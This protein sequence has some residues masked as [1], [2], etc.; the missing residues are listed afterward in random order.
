MN[1]SMKPL[2]IF[3]HGKVSGPKGN[4]IQAL[5]RVCLEQGFDVESLD[6]RRLHTNERVTKLNN[7]LMNLSRPYILVGTSMGGYVSAVAG[8]SNDPMGIFLI[9]PAVYMDGYA[10]AD[11]ERLECP[12]TVVHGWQDDIV[13]VENVIRF[14]QAAK[15]D[16]HVFDGGHRLREKLDETES[17]FAQFLR[18]CRKQNPHIRLQTLSSHYGNSIS[19]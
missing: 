13:P 14:A 8:L 1:P 2:V 4:R 7:Y 9:S 10:E 16:L 18:N 17:C 15:A 5:S 19:G 3:S 6:Y 12:V 11:L